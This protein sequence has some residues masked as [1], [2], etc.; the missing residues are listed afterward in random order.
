MERRQA[1]I[2]ADVRGNTL[3]GHASVFNQQTRIADWFEEV[4]P[5]FFD[6]ALRDGDDTVLQAEHQGLP[7]ART[8]S[9][10]L[11]LAK[12][13]TGLLFEADL[14]DTSLA[15][16]VRVL[17][18]RGDLASC[19]FGFTVAGDEWTTRG[20]GSPL[21]TLTDCGRL[22]DVSVVTFPAYEG[23]DVALRQLGDLPTPPTL[24]PRGLT[25]RDQIARITLARQLRK[26]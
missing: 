24:T 17:V 9:G 18:D 11:K 3:R 1:E 25:V 5:G 15:R 21:R 16:D 8:K 26:D 2:R 22:W 4:D 20:D 23:T 6:R 14:P 10:T 7:M 19:S 12:D 13:S